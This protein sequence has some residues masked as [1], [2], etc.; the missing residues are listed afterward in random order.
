MKTIATTVIERDFFVRR[1]DLLASGYTDQQIRAALAHREIFRVRQ[2]WYSVPN[3]PEPGVRAVRVGGRLT[4][5][6]AL[7]SYGVPVPRNS[8]TQVSV[9]AGASRLRDPGNRRKRL[10]DLHHMDIQW[11]EEPWMKHRSS[12]WRV[13]VQEALLAVLHSEGRDV[14]VACCDLVIKKKR[15]NARDV[16]ALFEHVPARVRAWRTLVDGRSGAHGE[17]YVRLWL[18]DAGIRFEPQPFMRGVGH[19][20]GQVSSWTYIEIDGAQHDEAAEGERSQFE[21]DHYRDTVVAING[22]RV[23]RFTY[24]QLYRQWALCLG[25][26]QRAMADDARRLVLE[27][28]YVSPRKLRTFSR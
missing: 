15:M 6:D 26:V 9:S 17:T 1:R 11:T 4:G 18:G 28:R 3:A 20:D 13:S 27:T 8:R 19:L 25:A 5:L 2:G 10:A 24:R 16:D 12:P 14:A 23:L 21:E 22:A 7:K